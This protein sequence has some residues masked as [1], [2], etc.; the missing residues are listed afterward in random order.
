MIR[1]IPIILR[2][3]TP[4]SNLFKE[5]LTTVP[6]WVKFYDVPISAFTADGLSVIATKLGTPLMLDSYASS[7][8]LESW[9][10]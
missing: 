2:K 10:G 3:W 1:N 9:G 8:C 4:N 7:M 5:D 6:I